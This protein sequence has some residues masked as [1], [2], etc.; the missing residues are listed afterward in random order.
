MK[1][2]ELF[3]KI[4]K[5][6][7]NIEK[8]FVILIIGTIILIAASAFLGNDTKTESQKIAQSGESFESAYIAD[9]E[10]R[11]TKVL[12]KV[13]GAGKVDV[14]ITIKSSKQIKLAK[15]TV[16]KSESKENGSSYELEEKTVITKDG[17]GEEPYVVSEY[18]PQIEGVMI[19]AQ[20]A[21]NIDVKTSL[22][23][24]VKSLLNVSANRVQ[25]LKGN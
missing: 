22:Y 3:S 25:V 6:N 5:N 16:E 21:D 23:E 19:V 14:V 1:F 9:L 4:T 20:G 7:K 15:D 24:G 10:K 2:S 18:Y 13:E 8:F 12:S 11:L 17:K